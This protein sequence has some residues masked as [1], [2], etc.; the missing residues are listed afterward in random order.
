MG[1]ARLLLSYDYAVLHHKAH[2]LDGGDV[3]ERIAGDG[4]DV[5][6][7]AGLELADLAFPAEQ[8]AR[9]RSCR[10]AG[11]REA[12]CRSGPSTP[13]RAACVPCGKGPT[14]EPTAK[15]IPAAICFLNSAIL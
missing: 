11:R 15:G 10:P 8:L 14:S 9:L 7:V 3:V 13:F 12:S 1:R 6:E 2:V 5:G 4:D